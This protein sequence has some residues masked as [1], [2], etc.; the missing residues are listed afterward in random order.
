MIRFLRRIVTALDD[1]L[2]KDNLRLLA[3]AVRSIVYDDAQYVL[4]LFIDIVEFQNRHFAELFRDL[5]ARFR[6]LLGPTLDRVTAQP[7]WC[8]LDPAFAL[9]TIY[10]F[11]FNYFVIERQMRGEQHLGARAR[12]RARTTAGSR[13]QRL[14]RIGPAQRA[15]RLRVPDRSLKNLSDRLLKS[16]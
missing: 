4:L 16:E 2:S 9:A 10:F 5:P 13:R 11:F 1:P 15:S 7:R 3:W 12:N 6:H 8:G 14:R